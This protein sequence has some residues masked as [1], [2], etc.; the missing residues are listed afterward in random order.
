MLQRLNNFE[1]RKQLKKVKSSDL[2][3]PKDINN[4]RRTVMDSKTRLKFT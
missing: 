4:L 1:A 2:S 3:V